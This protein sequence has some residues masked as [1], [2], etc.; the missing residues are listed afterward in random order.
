MFVT[1]DVLRL[2]VWLNADAYC[3]VKRKACNESKVQAKGR[4]GVGHWQQQGRSF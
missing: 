2:S 1:L 4:E 3:R